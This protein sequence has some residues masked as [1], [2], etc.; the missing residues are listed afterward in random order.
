MT[1]PPPSTP[2]SDIDGIHQDERPNTEVAAELGQ[3]AGTLQDI[4]KER[5]AKPPIAKDKE[6]GDDRTS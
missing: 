4:G 3:S 5:V 6:H 2:H 1:K